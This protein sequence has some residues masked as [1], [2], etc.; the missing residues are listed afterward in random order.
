MH[1]YGD[2]SSIHKCC[3]VLSR[4]TKFVLDVVEEVVR[5]K[6][7]EVEGETF[8]LQSNDDDNTMTNSKTKDLKDFK[9]K[10]LINVF[11]SNHRNASM[12]GLFQFNTL[13]IYK[14]DF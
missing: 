5:D 11:L 14:L 2:T 8:T 13:G 9:A 7:E 10:R 3:F 12:M 4:F 6:E 1:N